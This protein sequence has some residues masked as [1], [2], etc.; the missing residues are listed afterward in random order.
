[1]ARKVEQVN[2]NANA[3]MP[4]Q[5]TKVAGAVLTAQQALAFGVGRHLA[6]QLDVSAAIALNAKVALQLGEDLVLF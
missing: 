6:S 2:T 4:E 3:A 1:M 5:M